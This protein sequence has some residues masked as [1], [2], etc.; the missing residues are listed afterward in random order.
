MAQVSF[1][2][3]GDQQ[4]Y[5]TLNRN[6]VSMTREHAVQ[7]SY[8]DVTPVRAETSD[9]ELD[10]F[11]YPRN[12]SDPSAAA[13]RDSFQLTEGGYT[14][15]IGRVAG[16]LYVGRS[17]AGGYADSIDL[18]GDGLADVLLS[19]RCHFVVQ[20]SGHRITAIETDTAVTATVQGHIIKL[21]AHVPVYF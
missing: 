12:A 1:A 18:N 3:D 4:N 8:G 9:S 6:G 14:S 2:T 13:V 10:T 5:I 11:V 21:S 7:T 15:S 20:L 19:K 16:T 17:S